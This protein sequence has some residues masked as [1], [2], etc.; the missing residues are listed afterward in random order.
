VVNTDS[1]WKSLRDFITEAKKNPG[2]LTYGS[3]GFGTSYHFYGELFKIETATD[4][5]HVPLAGEAGSITGLL[6]G[7]IDMSLTGF[8]AARP[9]L[10]AGTLRALA[11]MYQKRVKDFPDIPTT[12]ELGY[13][14]LTTVGWYGFFLP[15]KTPR[16]IV[17]KLAKV[18]ETALK[19]AEVIKNIENVGMLVEV[20]TMD[21]ATKF[22]Q[23][24]EKKWREV[25]KK[26]K[27]A[28]E[29]RK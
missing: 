7:H 13:P 17:E 9:Y 23:Y 16:E 3:A 14:S 22:F 27:I 24:E 12:D 21:E 20:L 26:A 2:K 10:K 29:V 11:L 25:A 6:G 15:A 1:P 18:F 28:V 8:S 19:D 4:I 5:V